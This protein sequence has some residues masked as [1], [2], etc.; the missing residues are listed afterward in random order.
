MTRCY[1]V[2]GK[3]HRILTLLDRAPRG[4]E[5]IWRAEGLLEKPGP[6]RKAY[7]L[8]VGLVQEGFARRA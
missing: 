4:L 5:D 7:Y 1:S 2:N 3:A 6:R 8:V